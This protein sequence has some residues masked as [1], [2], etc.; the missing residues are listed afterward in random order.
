M[1]SR[2]LRCTVATAVLTLA[3]AGVLHAQTGTA[4][5]TKSAGDVVAPRVLTV[6][7]VLG[8]VNNEPITRTQVMERI[9]SMQGPKSPPLDSAIIDSLSPI[10]LKNLMADEIQLQ[11]AKTEK[12]EIAEADVKLKS[13]DDFKEVRSQFSSD[14]EMLRAVK[15]SGF[16]SLEDFKTKRADQL[17]NEMTKRDLLAKAKRDGK[18]PAVNV[19]E[20]DVTAAFD[21]EKGN[22]PKK[23]ATVG[24]RQ[25]IVPLNPSQASKDKARAKA[26][27]LR[28]E[29]IAH[30]DL[31]ESMA[32]H[33]SMDDASKELGGDLGWRRRG[34][35]V[36][37][38][39]RA[40]FSLNPGVISP[41]VETIYGYHIIRV[42]R[43]QPAEVKSRH[44]LI[45]FNV[46][47]S[48]AARSMRLADSVATLWR[49]G[50][51]YDTL[52]AHFHDTGNDELK[53]VP[54]FTR[55]SLPLSYQKAIRDHKAGDIVGPFPIAD[56]QLKLSKPAV[57]QLTK[58]EEAGD[59]TIAEWRERVRNNLI[60][61][62]SLRRF[63]DQLLSQAYIWVS[64]EMTVKKPAA[65]AAP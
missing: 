51:N 60:E 65:K 12:V 39:E 34:E 53:T 33:E 11:K 29:L 48:D 50:A 43:V 36:P 28:T 37:E 35:L 62:K 25:I 38:F 8:V 19:T 14:A 32:K 13:D 41:I 59:Y 20:A 5:A 22:L 45:K 49:N 10:V 52:V 54:E 3:G 58:V 2:S 57:L 16:A 56:D 23:P 17:R 44:I 46:D 24:F 9:F 26:D 55:D 63:I 4:A 7:K 42:D 1:A 30:P 21:A 47:S 31:F 40:I 27:S 18:I 6:N 61:Q 64:P 15:Q